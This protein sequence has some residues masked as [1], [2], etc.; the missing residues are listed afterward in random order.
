[1]METGRASNNTTIHLFY[2]WSP[3]S[4]ALLG[5]RKFMI[6]RQILRLIIYYVLPLILISIFYCLIAKTLFQKKD[7]IYS[8]NLS[9]RS[10]HNNSIQFEN[11]S[12]INTGRLSYD[13]MYGYPRKNTLT[14]DIRKTK[15]LRTRHKVAKTVLFLCLVFFIC[16]LPKQL[17]DLYW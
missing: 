10:F 2:C 7:V 17:H 3:N 5:N 9:K 6:T 16:W 14:Q 8:P 1:M 15:Q 11:R 4:H 13:I 12:I